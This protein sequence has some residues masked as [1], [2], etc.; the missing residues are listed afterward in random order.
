MNNQILELIQSFE[1]D[2]KSSKDKFNQFLIYV[3]F[4]FDKRIRNIKSEKTKN[5]YKKIKQ[6][7][8]QYILSHK[9]DIVKQIK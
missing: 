5:K 9:S 6:N 1:S 4:T 3:Y 2:A 8:L 7:I